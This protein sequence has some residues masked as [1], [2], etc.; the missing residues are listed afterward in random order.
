M[1][2]NTCEASTLPEEQAAPELTATPARSSPITNVSAFAPGTAMQLVL[3]NRSTRRR[4]H[5]RIRRDRQGTL[6]QLVPQLRHRSCICEVGGGKLGRDA[7]PD[8]AGDVL[9]AGATSPL[10]AAALDEWLDRGAVAEHESADA[11]RTADLV[12]RQ[13]Q[14]VGAERGHIE[15]DPSRRLNGV[16]MEK[17]A[18][19]VDDL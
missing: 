10:L 13:A 5:D 2:R 14:H 7:K 12:R 3:G 8:D 6:L 16:G 19:F 11:L 9:G 18:G 1:A 17:P 15:P 4:K